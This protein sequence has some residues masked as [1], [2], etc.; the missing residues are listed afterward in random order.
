[1][2]F[3]WFSKH[4]SHAACPGQALWKGLLPTMG[5][6]HVAATTSSAGVTSTRC[7]NQRA[8]GAGVSILQLSF[9]A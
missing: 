6:W 7:C 3:G 2:A 9:T 8:V 5:T 1:M 4:G